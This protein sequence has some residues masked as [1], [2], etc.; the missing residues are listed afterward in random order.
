MKE[1]KPTL[2]TKY[3]NMNKID[4]LSSSYEFIATKTIIANNCTVCLFEQNKAPD[5][6]GTT[7]LSQKYI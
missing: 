1:K 4:F 5:N 2:T 7:T 6:F 3:R